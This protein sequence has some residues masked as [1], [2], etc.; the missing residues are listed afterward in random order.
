MCGILGTIPSTNHFEFKKS[1]DSL[2]HR[3]P[4]DEGI[5]SDGKEITLGHRRLSI[6]DLTQAAHQPMI[7]Q[8]GRYVMV[9]NGEIYNFIEIRKELEKRGH[10]FRG[11]GDA[12]VLLASYEEWKENCLMKFNGMWAIAIWDRKIKNLFLSRD[13]FGKKPLFYTYAKGK[14]VFASEMKALYHFLPEIAPSNEFN[15]MQNNIFNYEATDKCLIKGIKRFPAGHW[16]LVKNNQ[17]TVFRYWNLLDNLVETPKNYGDQAD[18]FKDLFIDA[19]KVRMRSDVP[20]GTALSGG[21]DSSAVICTMSHV[22]INKKSERI[23]NNWQSAFVATFPDTF[24][25]ESIYANKVT[26]HLGIQTC[27][28]EID[29]KQHI[30]KLEEYLYQFEELF[31]TMPIPMIEIYHT[32]KNSGI[33]VTIDGHGADEILSGYPNSIL[34]ALFDVGFNRAHIRD[35]YHTYLNIIPNDQQFTKRKLSLYNYF[36]FVSI[37]YA[38]KLSG[39]RTNT[40]DASHKKYRKMDNLNKHLYI[41]IND[42]ILPTLLRNYDRYSMNSGV[43]IRMPFM[44]HRIISFCMSVPWYSKIRNGLSKALI[45]D[46]MKSILPEDIR[47][48]K[49]KI[50]FNCPLVEWIKGPFKYYFL[51]HIASRNFKECSL[52]N[53]K[54]VASKIKKVIFDDSVSFDQATEAWTLFSPYLWESSLRLRFK[55]DG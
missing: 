42:T 47:L 52:I 26:E 16:G 20:I 32:M 50:G 6:L 34:E 25:D 31:I 53:H 35:L 12:E 46:A 10:V 36:R 2:K 37:N 49:N 4:D 55:K 11:S 48:R 21:L 28:V 9:F 43:E 45:R 24:L 13:R 18:Q 54:N 23:S 27:L 7:S 3:G 17:L 41:L 30:D 1:L 33:S 14:I 38:K 51:D 44:D 8:S 22:G 19:C 5:W 39:L 15:W 29:P 40:K